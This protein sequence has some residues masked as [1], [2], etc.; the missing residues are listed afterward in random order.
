MRQ[1]NTHQSIFNKQ[2][3]NKMKKIIFAAVAA[4]VIAG[5]MGAAYAIE[6]N[7]KA[8]TATVTG[9]GACDCGGSSSEC[10]CDDA[11]GCCA[12]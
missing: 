4:V 2:K 9:C 7:K 5:S 1:P 8:A 10:T 12:Q 11:P 6:Q 3:S